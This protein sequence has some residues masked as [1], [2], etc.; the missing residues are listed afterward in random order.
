MLNVL[1]ERFKDR[2]KEGRSSKLDVWKLISVDLLDLVYT[3][4]AWLRWVTI[5]SKAVI[6]Y[7]FTFWNS[8]EPECW[9]NLIVTVWL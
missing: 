3:L 2:T 4:D 8:T 7:L 5:E 6:W 1:I 9:E